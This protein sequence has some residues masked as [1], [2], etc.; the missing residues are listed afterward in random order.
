MR[1]P[2]KIVVGDSLWTIR[3]VREVPRVKPLQELY[4]RADWDVELIT[5]KSGLPFPKK[6]ET[7]VH[8]LLHAIEAEYSIVIPHALVHK[9]D[10]PIA[11]LL[12][13]N[14]L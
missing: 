5:I 9:L 8:E 10:A 2:K 12:L 4:G 3:Q 6:L 14:F 11:R 13:D 7:L 1:L